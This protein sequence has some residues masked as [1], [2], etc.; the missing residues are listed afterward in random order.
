[1]IE[2]I[3][4]LSIT[5]NIIIITIIS[6]YDYHYYYYYYYYYLGRGPRASSARQASKAVR[7]WQALSAKPADSQ[8]SW[9]TSQEGLDIVASLP[10]VWQAVR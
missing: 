9:Q 7:C 2:I 3:Q 10:P 8:G 6:N 1:M 5:N 4:R